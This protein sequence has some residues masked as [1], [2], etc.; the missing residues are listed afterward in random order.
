MP[1]DA[2]N[3]FPH[4]FLT[5]VEAGKRGFNIYIEKKQQ[6]QVPLCLVELT[7]E[8]ENLKKAQR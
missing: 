8:I 5:L 1:D 6:Q 3:F 2:R 7:L 4:T